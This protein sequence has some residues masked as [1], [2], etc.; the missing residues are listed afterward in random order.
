MAGAIAFTE[1]QQETPQACLVDLT[2]P[3]GGAVS[4]VALNPDG[5]IRVQWPAAADVSEPIRYNVFMK[6][7]TATG[8]FDDE[9]I[10]GCVKGLFLDIY[11]QVDGQPLQL[12]ETYHFG[13]RAEDALGNVNQNT[14]SL[15]I[16]ASGLQVQAL[17]SQILATFVPPCESIEVELEQAEIEIETGGEQ[18]IE[19]KIEEC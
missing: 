13:V 3:T 16:V 17:V 18:E 4:G 9:N 19:I 14:T 7:G 15:S 11:R 1:M 10:I 2:P 5:S 6:L 12:G 8:L